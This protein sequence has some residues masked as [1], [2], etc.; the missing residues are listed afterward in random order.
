L[1]LGRVTL[2]I[3]AIAVMMSLFAAVANAATIEG[4]RQSD[5]LIESNRN[6]TISGR[7]GGDLID[8]RRFTDDR[9]EVFGDR[10]GDEMSVRD[11]DGRDTVIGGKGY[12]V[13]VGD[14]RDEL[15]CEEEYQ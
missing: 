1:R 13:C 7:Q 4:T 9:D 3:A 15:N 2:M 5:R 12:D 8:A 14:A 6:D 11:D 10:G